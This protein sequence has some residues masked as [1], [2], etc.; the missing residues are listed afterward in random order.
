MP[1]D[2]HYQDMFKDIPIDQKRRD[3]ACNPMVQHLDEATDEEVEQLYF[4]VFSSMDRAMRDV[5]G[6]SMF[7]DGYCE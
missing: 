5:I 7:E 2:E 3:L 4:V 6:E 1:N